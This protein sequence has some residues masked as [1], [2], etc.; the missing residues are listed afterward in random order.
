MS[1]DHDSPWYAHREEDSTAAH[2]FFVINRPMLSPVTSALQTTKK[3]RT[4]KS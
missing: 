3:P 4:P 2:V 1:A